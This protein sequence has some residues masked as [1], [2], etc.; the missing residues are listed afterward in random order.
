MMTTQRSGDF[1]EGDIY[2]APAMNPECEAPS[3]D[4]DVPVKLK[5]SV[6]LSCAVVA[7]AG[8]ADRTDC[9]K[10]RLQVA[11][12]GGGAQGAHPPVRS[13][14]CLGGAQEAGAQEVV[15]TDYHLQQ[16]GAVLS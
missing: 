12:A 6:T 10:T 11:A 2:A 7:G 1:L 13:H 14:S 15:T 5:M 16:P 3:C 8:A 4:D 9:G